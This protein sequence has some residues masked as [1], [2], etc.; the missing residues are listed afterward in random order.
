MWFKT[1]SV[2]SS[3]TSSL[4][5]SV[6]TVRRKSCKFEG[7]SGAG[8]LP[9]ISAALVRRAMIALW[10]ATLAFD[11]PAKGV[12]ATHCGEARSSPHS[13]VSGLRQQPKEKHNE[14]NCHK[15]HD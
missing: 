8:A 2:T 5:N 10:S 15:D 7:V 6:A 9:P 3:W 4:C 13:F 12:P 14:R 11:Y 1:A